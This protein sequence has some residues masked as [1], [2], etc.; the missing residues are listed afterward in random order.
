MNRL[1][2]LLLALLAAQF[3]SA[4]K[5]TWTLTSK[6]G[7]SI[8]VDYIFYDGVQLSFKKVGGMN[9]IKIDP[10]LLN[11]K[12]WKALQ[13][14]FSKKAK[15]DLE[16]TRRTKTSTDTDRQSYS[17]YYDTYTHTTK[18]IEKLNLFYVEVESSSHFETALTVEYFIFHKES[19]EYGRIPAKV[20]LR[21]PF[22]TVLEKTTAGSTYSSSY[23]GYGTYY[24]SGSG[25]T[26]AEAAVILLDSDGNE[27]NSYANSTKLMNFTN[28]IK[29]KKREEYAKADGT[30]KNQKKKKKKKPAN[31]NNKTID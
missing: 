20:S 2:I 17:G 8:E 23:A 29:A 31:N 25:A 14:D 12:S 18:E 22:E 28:R 27:I 6:D 4:A 21:E 1:Y 26:T 11:E 19:I 5:E 30:K 7:H 24:R 3:A 10:S 13:A 15:I 9:K 16:V